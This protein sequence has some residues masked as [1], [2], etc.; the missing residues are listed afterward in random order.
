MVLQHGS[1]IAIDEASGNLNEIHVRIPITGLLLLRES[2]KA[3]ENAK[4]VIETPEGEVSYHVPI[5]KES[6]F[7][8]DRIFEKDLF[9]LIPFYIFNYEKEL[10]AINDDEDKIDAL[11]ELYKDIYDRLENAQKEGRLSSQSFGV[12]IGLTHSVFSKITSGHNSS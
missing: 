9:F 5:M 3:P 10:K 7:T 12:I 1:Q 6:D 11:L 8:I 2:K 4:I